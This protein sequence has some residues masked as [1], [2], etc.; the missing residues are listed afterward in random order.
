MRIALAA[1]QSQIQEPVTPAE[2]DDDEDDDGGSLSKNDKIQMLDMAQE[3]VLKAIGF[4][5][6]AERS[7][8]NSERNNKDILSIATICG[9]V[10]YHLPLPLSCQRNSSLVVSRPLKSC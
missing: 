4:M 6:D 1:N 8:K 7:K 5:T 9:L 3:A 2:S 10:N